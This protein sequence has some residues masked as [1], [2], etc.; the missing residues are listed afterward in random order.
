MNRR[1]PVHLGSVLILCAMSFPASAWYQVEVIVFEY[2]HPDADGE[3]WQSNPG[4]SDGD[5]STELNLGDAAAGSP[6]VAYRM[7]SPAHF[8]LG[9]VYQSLRTSHDYRPVL[10]VAWEQPGSGEGPARAVHLEQSPGVA[11]PGNGTGD[12]TSDPAAALQPAGTIVDGTVRVRSGRFLHVDVD[13]AY[14]PQDFRLQA[15]AGTAGASAAPTLDHVR[16]RTSRK[17]KLNELQYLDH[18][19]FGVI[20]EVSRL[21]PDAQ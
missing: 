8:R 5:S 4:L 1:V 2:L 13:M 9:G 19:L 14:F 7:I 15:D 17:I 20:V 11:S 21:R 12:T 16:M 18:P 10:H 3:L 6:F